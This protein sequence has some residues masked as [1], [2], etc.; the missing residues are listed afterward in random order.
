MFSIA[1]GQNPDSDHHGPGYSRTT[2]ATPNPAP[3]SDFDTWWPIILVTFA[4]SVLG[5]IVVYICC[6]WCSRRRLLMPPRHGR[7][8]VLV[9]S[10][11]SPEDAS[12]GYTDRTE[13]PGHHGVANPVDFPLTPPPY[14]DKPPEYGELYP[15]RE[16]T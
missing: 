11:D 10:V 14:C 6:R 3:P 7:G 5:F 16:P 9:S 8:V 2:N 12:L 4:A 13:D 1:S 15:H